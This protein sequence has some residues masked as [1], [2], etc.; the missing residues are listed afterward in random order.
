M[1]SVIQATDADGGQTVDFA[2]ISQSVADVFRVVA[3][4]DHS[5]Q[6]EVRTAS[7][8]YEALV[9]YSVTLR[10]TDTGSPP[11]SGDATYTI[12]VSTPFFKP[13]FYYCPGCIY[14]A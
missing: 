1:R 9:S 13:P 3:S 12:T 6:L 5:A 4:T 11:L 7:L 8:N 14:C 2:I 10:A